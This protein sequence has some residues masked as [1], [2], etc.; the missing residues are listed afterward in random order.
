[1]A[2]V[3][4]VGCAGHSHYAGMESR[5]IKALAPADIDGLKAG[6][7]MSMALAAELNGYA[8]PLHVLELADR[9]SLTAQ[10]RQ[11]T[12]ELYRRM[13]AQAVARGEEV[14]ASERALDQ[15]F[16]RRAVTP[17]ALGAALRRVGEAQAAVRGVHLQAHL[18][19]VRILTPDQVSRYNELRG[20]R[21]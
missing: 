10:Q 6:R 20:Y 12:Q 5:E 8:G 2:A 4:L 18:E 21:L 13:Q 3:L 16:A 9:L 7:G 15:L 1:M 19:Q 11:A 14:I 17:D